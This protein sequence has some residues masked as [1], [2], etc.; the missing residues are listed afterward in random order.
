[1]YHAARACRRSMASTSAA[2][3]PSAAATWSTR[4]RP[5]AARACRLRPP[6]S[7]CARG[8][9]RS[10]AWRAAAR[11]AA[12]APGSR[13][14]PRPSRGRARRGRGAPG[15]PGRHPPSARPL[16]EPRLEGEGTSS[17]KRSWSR[18]AGLGDQY[19]TTTRSMTATAR[20]A[21]VRGRGR[22]RGRG[23]GNRVGCDRRTRDD[24]QRRDDSE[25]RRRGACHSSRPEKLAH[26]QRRP[27]RRSGRA[28]SSWARGGARSRAPRAA[29]AGTRRRTRRGRGRGDRAPRPPRAAAAGL[30]S[31]LRERRPR[32]PSR[33]DLGAGSSTDSGELSGA[34]L[35][36]A[37]AFA[38][39]AGLAASSTGPSWAWRPPPRRGA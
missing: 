24:R 16:G 29:P 10:D 39:W 35:I 38:A 13:A 15:S 28:R 37:A 23:R 11:R 4:E 25:P 2:C 26:R 18:A 30:V 20:R 19:R 9:P 3:S 12:C 17:R 5:P 14:S 34:G 6:R 8:R 27:L 22:R 36:P 1:M 31:A 21:A 33:P 7:G 32:V